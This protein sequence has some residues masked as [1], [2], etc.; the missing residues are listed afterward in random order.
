MVAVGRYKF[1][2]L[3]YA[4]HHPIYQD[5]VFFDL[6]NTVSYLDEIK[7]ML[8]ENI[9]F[10]SSNLEHNHQGGEWDF[11]LEDKIKRHK[12]VA[13]KGQIS[14]DMWRTIFKETD[15][16]E[17]IFKKA[18]GCLNVDTKDVYRDTDLYHEIVSCRALFYILQKC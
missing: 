7:K 9:T 8:F 14:A 16:I 4:F 3:F 12:M 11:S 5:I 6:L 18:E 15:E 13:P 1:M 10:T 2:P 17:L